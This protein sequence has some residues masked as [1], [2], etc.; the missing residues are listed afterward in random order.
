MRDYILSRWPVESGR[1]VLQRDATG[2]TVVEL[3]RFE[4]LFGGVKVPSYS[5]FIAVERAGKLAGKLGYESFFQRQRSAGK[6]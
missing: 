5:N 4:A 1:I 3:E 6:L 2:E